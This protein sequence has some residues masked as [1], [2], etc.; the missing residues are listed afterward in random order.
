MYLFV[1]IPEWLGSAIQ[2]TWI[3][4]L[5]W[6]KKKRFE[7][8]VKSDLDKDKWVRD[9]RGS[10]PEPD[11][12]GYL[13]NKRETRW[14]KDNVHVRLGQLMLTDTDGHGRRPHITFTKNTY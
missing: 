4:K 9:I 2:N 13:L 6:T 11:K 10:R 1:G 5:D 7:G 8:W 3:S 14:T 12:T